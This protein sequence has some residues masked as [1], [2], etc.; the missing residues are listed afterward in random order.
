MASVLK[1]KNENGEWIDVPYF[2]AEGGGETGGGGTSAYEQVYENISLNAFGGCSVTGEQAQ[3]LA[4]ANEIYVYAVLGSIKG[5]PS[6]FKINM[7]FRFS[8]NYTHRVEREYKVSDAGENS[9]PTWLVK[10][11]KLSAQKYV[12]EDSFYTNYYD[13][14]LGDTKFNTIEARQFFA[15]QNMPSGELPSLTFSVFLG[16]TSGATIPGG[17]GITIWAR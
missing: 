7:D 9:G 16:T 10:L 8:T 2:V 4:N 13:E 11:T 17:Y 3:K 14:S 1:V 12:V 15:T 6:D 5:A